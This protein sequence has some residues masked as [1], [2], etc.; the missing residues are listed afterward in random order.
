M[1]NPYSEIF[2]APGAKAFSAAGFVARLPLSMITLGIVTMLSETHGEY[3]LAGAVS[4]TFA[5][6]SGLIA[7]QV[8]RLVDRHGQRRVLVPAT[9]ISVSALISLM[10]ATHL[11]AP[12]WTLFLFAVL[13]GA[14]PSFSSFVR[15]RWTELYRGSSKLHTAFAFESVVDEAVFMVGP[16]LA[17]G[18]SVTVFPEAGPLTATIFLTIGS[19]LFAAQRSTEP[20][21]HAQERSGGRSVIRLGS[22][23]I[24]VL[25][26]ASIGA[27]F[28]TAEVAAVAFAEAQGNKA[29][30]S[31]ALS[32]YAS[33]SL[34][35]GLAFGVLKLNMPL[36]RQLLIMIALAALTTL[37]LLI[38][39]NIPMLCLVLFVAGV[40][41]SPTII[42][43]MA[44]VEKLVP[45]S[46]LTEGMTWAIT[47]IGIGLAAGSSAAGWV[48]DTYGPTSGFLVSI[49][50]G[51]VAFIVALGGQ[52]SLQRSVLGATASA[53]A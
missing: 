53:T 48:I 4:A 38:V 47:S 41:V 24:I 20:P 46:K 9:L 7:P 42:T 26:L 11:K 16:I 12:D 15:A 6:A 8:S 30:A 39:S 21:I 50:A 18:L 25:T 43:A 36:A 1:R 31:F 33:G 52:G 45:S 29:A 44:L 19:L 5:L 40:A 13:S 32:A 28:G 14:M 27:I 3:W 2:Q 22:L 23:Q 51:V 17:V 10:V 37:P 34:I 49:T 35:A